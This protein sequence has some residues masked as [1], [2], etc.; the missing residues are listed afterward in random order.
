MCTI[1]PPDISYTGAPSRTG[2]RTGVS[3]LHACR[4]D[5]PGFEYNA[6]ACDESA[7]LPCA[8][9]RAHTHTH[10]HTHTCTHIC[11]H[12]CTHI[13]T[14]ICTHSYMHTHTHAH[15]YAHTYAHTHTCTHMHTH[16]HTHT[17]TF[18][19]LEEPLGY[20]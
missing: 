3:G 10:T 15:T 16:A 4:R 11:T 6:S 8:K 2:S 12:T 19:T 17:H 20:P 14:H 9:A 7:P 18:L 13:C 1:S 5:Q